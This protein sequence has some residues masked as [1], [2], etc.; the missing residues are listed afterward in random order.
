MPELLRA[1]ATLSFGQLPVPSPVFAALLIPSPASTGSDG[2]GDAL[3]LR[4]HHGRA[5][6]GGPSAVRAE[7][8][9]E[10]VDGPGKR[11]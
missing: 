9:K 2:P 7:E 10:R 11:C 4:V 5:G 3:G 8:D 1:V 6:P